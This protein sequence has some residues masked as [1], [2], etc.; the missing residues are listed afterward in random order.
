MINTGGD[1]K[2]FARSDPEVQI[3][4][5]GVGP[6]DKVVYIEDDREWVSERVLHWFRR[7]YHALLPWENESED[8]EKG[9]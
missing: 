5:S 8:E 6:K 7:I 1:V 4:P 3:L 2:I 9:A